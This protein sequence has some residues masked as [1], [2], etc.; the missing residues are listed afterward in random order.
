MLGGRADTAVLWE[1]RVRPSTAP[2][3][4][5]RRCSGRSRPGAD[6]DNAGSS[7]SR[8]VNLRACRFYARMGCTLASIDR[9]A[10]PELPEETQLIWVGDLAPTGGS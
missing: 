4:S 10:Y 6:T 1:L 5:V 8:P 9:S 3:G 2:Q 7:R